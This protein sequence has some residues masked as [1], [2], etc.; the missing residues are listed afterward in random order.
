MQQSLAGFDQTNQ[1]VYGAQTNITGDVY[2]TVLSGIFNAPVTVATRIAA[3]AAAGPP[4]PQ[5]FVGRQTEL[6]A[7]AEA[8]T[9]R[10]AVVAITGMGGIGKTTLARKVAAQVAPQFGGGVFWAAL[11]DHGGN[12]SP[13]LDTWARLC[14][15]DPATL[16]PDPAAR[17][18]TVRG[19][20]TERSQESGNILVVI[21]D[22][23]EEWAQG[24]EVLQAARPLGAAL[25]MT[26]R[27]A[28]LAADAEIYPLDALPQRDALALLARLGG[29]IVRQQQRDAQRLLDQVAGLPKALE[30]AGMLIALRAKK[31]GWQL[32]ALVDALTQRP[33]DEVLRLGGHAGLAATFLVSYN[34]LDVQEQRAFR[35]LAA[36]APVPMTA[37]IIGVAMG[38]ETGAVEGL[39]DTLVSLSLVNWV[40]GGGAVRYAEHPLLYQFAQRMTPVDER[41]A[42]RAP[43]LAALRR[44]LTD[45]NLN[46]NERRFAGHRL[47]ALKWLDSVEDVT[48]ADLIA[49]LE[50]IGRYVKSSTQRAYL[51]EV[52]QRY[53][54]KDD[55]GSATPD[56][57]RR[58][59]LL[60]YRTSFLASAEDLDAGFAEA[61]KARALIEQLT[62][63]GDLLPEDL[64]LRA[65][66]AYHLA[67]MEGDRYF[68]NPTPD[69]R[70]GLHRALRLYREA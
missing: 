24:V 39:L 48:S 31:P 68:A 9:T 62:S 11:A 50:L 46:E 32:A 36:F 44:A 57:R 6:K 26:T 40:P 37:A 52:I 70:P 28:E 2:G 69:S 3:A 17:G 51:A 34:S 64:L 61:G 65:R 30:M 60:V 1:T 5:Y 4:P 53:L 25:L 49:Y 29:E 66:N 16:A 7:I 18:A 22:L 8:L 42:F 47:T 15:H 63:T 21:D 12:P 67:N 19:F 33:A 55:A 54:A 23:R 56:L 58:A 38:L 45:P 10:H 35:A 14:G 59:Q 27:N 43:V 13:V 20:L 41:E